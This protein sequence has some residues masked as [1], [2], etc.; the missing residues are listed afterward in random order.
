MAKAAT[1]EKT[2]A[3]KAKHETLGLT[4]E[5]LKQIYATM[6]LSRVLD[7]R[8]WV[9]QRQGKAAFHISGMG[10]EA[11]QVAAARAMEKGKDFLHPY[12]RDMAMVLFW[13]MTPK[14]LLLSLLAKAGEPASGAHQMPAH[15]GHRK[16]NIVSGSSPVATQIPQAVGIALASK[17]RKED[18]VTLVAFGEGATSKGDFHEAANFAGIH[19]LPV[20]FLC[21]NNLYAI[22][23]HQS[24]QMAIED[25]A[26]RA[27]GYG[28][29]GVVVDGNDVLACYEVMRIAVDRARKGEGPTLVEAKT[30]RIVPH[31][32]DDD[33][34]T[35]RS[36]EEVEEW[37]KRDPIPRFRAYLQ[38]QGIL[39]A[40]GER[41]IRSW[42][43]KQVDEATEFA[44]KAPLPD[45]S[46]AFK[47]VYA[48]E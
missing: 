31:S 17:I 36:R 18:A 15:Y 8:M 38:E 1:K 39:D 43:A 45:P 35:Y 48:E 37:K 20:V 47:N 33:D 16:L 5:D 29:P 42:A 11:L 10:H 12:Y 2:E 28:F 22:S 7:E 14:E 41:E 21:E 46:E 32:S 4:A 23:V 24:K 44:E 27:P 9:L 6:V 25:V 13:G 26:D 3:K 30:Y 19:K 40:Q 34:R